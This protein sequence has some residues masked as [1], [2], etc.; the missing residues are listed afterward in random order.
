MSFTNTSTFGN[1]YS[2]DFG[3]GNTS[4]AE[5]PNHTYTQPGSYEVGF[6]AT[7][8]CGSST[9]N[10]IVVI[11]FSF[12]LID[13]AFSATSGCAP[14]E[15]EITDQTTNNPISWTWQFPG[16]TPETSTEQNPTVTYEQAGTYSISAEIAN[17]DGSST[18]DFTDV[19][20]VNDV[21]TAEFEVSELGEMITTI[22][23][24]VGAT[25]YS[26]D[27]GDGATSDDAQPEHVYTETGV[28]EITL[29]A[30]NECGTVTSTT[31]VSVTV[32][33][34]AELSAL[35]Q[36]TISPNPSTGIINLTFAEAV[37]DNIQY[38]VKDMAGRNI[39]NGIIPLGTQ[40][41]TLQIS[42]SG[43]YLIVLTKG[44][45]MDVKKLNVID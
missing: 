23:N 35:G 41:K 24:S 18:F 32:S 43:L 6:T 17:A 39:S 2:W 13:A 38:Q 7:N 5:N 26:W 34:I 3:D 10:R 19:I 33:S 45:K 44:D 22:N 8:D 25:S 15:V 14:F 31:T 1:T 16:G 4:T 9:I 36:W 11:D 28:Y 29:S 27:F 21:P 20:I 12:P 40:R 42:D 37:D 30:T